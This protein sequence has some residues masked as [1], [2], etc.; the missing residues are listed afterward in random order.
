MA[1]INMS[2]GDAL[3]NID[4]D[5]QDPPSLIE[6][7]VKYWREEKYDVV[8]TNDDFTHE[9]YS[10]RGKSIISVELKSRSDLSGTNIRNLISTDQNWKQFLPSGT[11]DVLSEIDPKKRLSDL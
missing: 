10:K 3:I 8:F 4:I 1:G 7:M 2:T 5:L 6:Q 9:L 11:I